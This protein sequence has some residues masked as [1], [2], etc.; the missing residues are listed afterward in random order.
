ML[1]NGLS[2]QFKMCHHVYVRIVELFILKLEVKVTNL[3][4][5]LIVLHIGYAIM[6]G[7]LLS[8]TDITVTWLVT[9]ILSMDAGVFIGYDFAK[10]EE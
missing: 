2:N 6:G 10:T 9:V 5:K 7:S 1:K 3:I 8:N 4:P